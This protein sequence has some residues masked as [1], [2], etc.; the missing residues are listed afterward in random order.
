[1]QHT[2]VTFEYRKIVSVKV[3]S[4]ITRNI[5]KRSLIQK[6]YWDPIE[7]S[8]IQHPVNL[9]FQKTSAPHWRE[10]VVLESR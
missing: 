4:S 5:L 9:A 7:Q 8:T 3:E 6:L 2:L 1:M 10:T